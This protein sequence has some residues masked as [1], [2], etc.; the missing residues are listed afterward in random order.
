MGSLRAFPIVRKVLNDAL[1]GVCVTSW[2]PEV[3]DRVYPLVNV[4]SLGGSR[5]PRRPDDLHIPV[6]ELTAYVDTEI[7][8]SEDLYD[9]VLDALFE[10]QHYQKQTPGGYIHSIRETMG[11]TQFDSPFDAT[12]RMQGLVKLGIRPPNG[13][14]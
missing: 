6:L 4:R 14:N 5:H 12:W 9:S 10:A 7:A 3:D 8:D 1:P 11:K 2:V 13:G